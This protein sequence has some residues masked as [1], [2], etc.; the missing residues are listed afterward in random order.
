MSCLLCH[1]GGVG[2]TACFI[3]IDSML[4]RVKHENSV[5]IYGHVT[6]LR[7][8]AQLHGTNGGK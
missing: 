1:S 7:S 6:V 8:A 5:D 4:E 3:V 2:R